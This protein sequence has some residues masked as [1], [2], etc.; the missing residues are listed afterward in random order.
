LKFKGA[1]LCYF[2]TRKEISLVVDF[3][4]VLLATVQPSIILIRTIFMNERIIE[5]G[6]AAATAGYY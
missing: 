3:M 4:L 2:L 5:L 1:P 6:I